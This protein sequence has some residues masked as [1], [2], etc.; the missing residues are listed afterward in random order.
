CPYLSPTLVQPS[1][2]FTSFLAKVPAVVFAEE[3]RAS[4]FRSRENQFCRDFEARPR[5][6]R[7]FP[8]FPFISQ[9]V[10][11]YTSEQGRTSEVPQAALNSNIFTDTALTTKLHV[12]Q[13]GVCAFISRSTVN[14]VRLGCVI[15]ISIR[16]ARNT[17]RALPSSLGSSE[18]R[19]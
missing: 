14:I 5:R 3:N 17:G 12:F 1:W 6:R 9:Q 16:H 15:A 11:L 10:S 18:S 4:A 8:T 2:C 7:S 13:E 19:R